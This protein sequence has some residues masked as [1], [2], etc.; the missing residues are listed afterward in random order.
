[1]KTRKGREP[2]AFTAHIALAVTSAFAGDRLLRRLLRLF[3]LP[4]ALLLY[5]GIATG[6][7]GWSRRTESTSAA[8]QPHIAG[9]A[10]ACRDLR[11]SGPSPGGLEISGVLPPKGKPL[12]KALDLFLVDQQVMRP[13]ILLGRLLEVAHRGAELVDDPYDE[14]VEFAVDDDP[15]LGVLE[16]RAGWVFA[17]Q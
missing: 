4:L 16:I 6:R 7:R 14:I 12:G 9:P 8:F 17:R 10:S 15:V 11:L 5:Q 1:M 2:A 13:E 3:G